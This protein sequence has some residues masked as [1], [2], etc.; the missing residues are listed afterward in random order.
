ME[1]EWNK[2]LMEKRNNTG[3]GQNYGEELQAGVTRER[4]IGG[5]TTLTRLN[6][7]R[8]WDKKRS[9]LKH[10]DSQPQTELTR[11]SWDFWVSNS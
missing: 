3:I 1:V 6:I 2:L 9:I 4:D 5:G 11:L 7:G 10:F 8:K